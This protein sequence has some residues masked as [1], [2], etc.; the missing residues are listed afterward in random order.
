MKGGCVGILDKLFPPKP[1]KIQ[2]APLDPFKLRTPLLAF[3]TVDFITGFDAMENT[4][5]FG[6]PGSGKSS[7][8]GALYARSML[9]AGY[10]MLV[11]CPKPEDAETWRRY[12][13]AEGREADLIFVR[14]GGPWRFNPLLWEQRRAGRGANQTENL[15]KVIAGAV[16]IARGKEIGRASCR[17]RV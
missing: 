11:L 7:S 8:S 4:V 12:A 3:S 2:V 10:G 6:N 14:P 15:V 1:A 9:A 16:E 13:Q 17:E 5:I